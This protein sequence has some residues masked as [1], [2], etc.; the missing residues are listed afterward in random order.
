MLKLNDNN[1]FVGEIKQLLHDFNLPKCEVGTFSNDVVHIDGDKLIYNN[2][3][4]LYIYNK[5]YINLTTNLPIRNTLYDSE[6][7]RYLGRYL[8]FIRDYMGVDLL[9]MY[10]ALDYQHLDYDYINGDFKLLKSDGDYITY[11]LPVDVNMKYTIYSSKRVCIKVGVIEKNKKITL[12]NNNGECLISV[13]T[14]QFPNLLDLSSKFKKDDIIKYKNTTNIVIRVP[15]TYSGTLVVLYGDY[16]KNYINVPCTSTSNGQKITTYIKQYYNTKNQLMSLDNDQNYLISDRLYE[17]L[18]GNAISPLSKDYDIAKLQKLLVRG[19]LL[20]SVNYYGIWS[21]DDR[22]RLSILSDSK[23]TNIISDKYDC[24]G[25]CDKDV[26]SAL[27]VY[28][29]LI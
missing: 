28:G 24:I 26:E 29:G 9:S 6:T 11:I 7:H 8:R 3:S 18:C 1:L 14:N 5:Q 23:I 13:S 25:Y 10:N 12:A 17:Y 21:D 2:H 20:S 15:I 19:K 4:E 16:T 22:E 27:N